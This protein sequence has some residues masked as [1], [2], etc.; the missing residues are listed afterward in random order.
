MTC[1]E[2]ESERVITTT[3]QPASNRVLEFLPAPGQFVNETGMA[4]YTGQKSFEEARL[5]AENRLKRVSSSRS[6]TSAAT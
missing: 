4:G 1:Y 6:A 2:R 5:Y 3:G